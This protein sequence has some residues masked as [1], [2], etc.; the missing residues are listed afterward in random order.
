MAYQAELSLRCVYLS[1]I[2]AVKRL[3]AIMLFLCFSAQSMAQVVVLG[4]FELNKNYIATN[5][6]ENRA[7]PKSTC[8][9]KCYLG[10]QLKKTGDD[11]KP[12]GNAPA[13]MAKAEVL[14]CVLPLP[15]IQFAP[16]FEAY[17]QPLRTP[18]EKPLHDRL[19]CNSVFHPPAVAC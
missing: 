17:H 15:E 5:L 11:E 18:V 9:G 14:P 8:C 13:K 6:C 10:K 4:L 7:K 12:S 3:I 16:A 1:Y 19:C 2:C